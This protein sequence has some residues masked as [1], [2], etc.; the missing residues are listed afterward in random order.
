MVCRLI[1]DPCFREYL[2]RAK[3]QFPIIGM[4]IVLYRAP[5]IYISRHQ[6]QKRDP[7]SV[8]WSRN[9]WSRRDKANRRSDGDARSERQH[10]QARVISVQADFPADD[11]PMSAYISW[12]HLGKHKWQRYRADDFSDTPRRFVTKRG[13]PRRACNRPE[14]FY[15][16]E[17][18]KKVY[19]TLRLLAT[20]YICPNLSAFISRLSL[21]P[22][23]S[24]ARSAR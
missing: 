5:S 11:M 6:R 18:C 8:D 10:R 20:I 9:S 16:H 7:F 17:L 1:C 4:S 3:N 13:E 12:L 14:S 21:S 19:S 2:T 15:Q 22:F 23:V 24:R